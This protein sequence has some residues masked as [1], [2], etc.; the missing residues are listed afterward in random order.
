MGALGIES[1]VRCTILNLQRCFPGG[2]SFS[3]EVLPV[4]GADTFE[5]EKLGGVPE[6]PKWKGTPISLGV[7]RATLTLS[8]LAL[9]VAHE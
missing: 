6:E 5:R 3:V 7:Y 8:V 1:G 9:T 2:Q 4:D